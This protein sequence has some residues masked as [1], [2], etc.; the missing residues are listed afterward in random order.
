MGMKL[1]GRVRLTG[2][3]H[4]ELFDEFGNLKEERWTSNIVTTVGVYHVADQLS[5]IPDQAAMSYMAVGTDNTAPV[6]GNTALGAEVGRVG[7]TGRTD[8]AG[9]ITYVGYFPSGTGT[10]A[11]QEAGILNAA[12]GG[13]LLA[14]LTYASLTKATGDTLTI[15]WTITVSDDGV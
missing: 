11:L 15:T 9:V 6:A 1:N 12:S 7:L 4:L 3:A 14:R 8:S 10:G 13:I 5:A 2:R